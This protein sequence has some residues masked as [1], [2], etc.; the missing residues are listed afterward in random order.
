MAAPNAPPLTLEGLR[1]R[2]ENETSLSPTVRGELRSK[3]KRFADVAGKH[4]SEIIA[5]P[6]VIRKVVALANWQSAGLSKKGWANVTSGVTRAMVIAGIKVHRRRRNF[7]LSLSWEDLLAQM[8]RR[9]HDEIHRF[10]GWCS[11][12][13][14]A[15]SSVDV[16]TFAAY[17]DYLTKETIQT[18]PRERWHVARRAWNRAVV[19][20]SKAFP[21]IPDTVPPGWRGLGWSAF[22]EALV[23]EFEQYEKKMLVGDLLADEEIRPLKPITVKG[24]KDKFRWYLSRLVESGVPIETFSSLNACITVDLVKRGIHAHLGGRLLDDKTRPGLHAMMTAILSIANHVGVGAEQQAVFGKLAR[25]VRHRPTGMTEK[26]RNRLAQF[27]DREARRMFIRVPFLVAQ[28]L[29]DIADPTAHQALRMQ[30]AAIHALL[31]HLPV[32]VKNAAMLDLDKHIYRPPGQKAGRWRVHFEEGEVKNKVVIDAELNEKT[33]ALLDLY[34]RVFRP[35]LMK[36]ATSRLFINQHGVAKETGT[37]SKQFSK[38]VKRETGF[39]VNA[40]LLRHFAAFTFLEANP[41]HYETVRQLL[42]HKDIATTIRFYAGAETMNAL[43]RYDRL[44]ARLMRSESDGA[45]VHVPKVHG[46]DAEDL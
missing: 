38:F 11:V 9:D 43:E 46:L 33:S 45:K 31:L 34:V 14:M 37:V 29:K 12:H 32:R 20:E 40:H 16:A 19:T 23:A 5:D 22:P 44:L 25:K 13:Q 21:V 24:Y 10:A 35:R 18:N 27:K 3:L 41:G 26:N 7:K 42:G 15:P 4:P 36:K 6:A 1:A 8:S 30:Y 17:L 28:E 2:L 39:I